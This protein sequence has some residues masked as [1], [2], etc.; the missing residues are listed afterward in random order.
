MWPFS[1]IEA[2]CFPAQSLPKG[3]MKNTSTFAR[4]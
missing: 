2:T 3:K 1:K 4:S